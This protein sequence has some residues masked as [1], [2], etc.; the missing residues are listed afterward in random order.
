[1]TDHERPPCPWCSSPVGIK[2][3]KRWQK[4]SYCPHCHHC[5]EKYLQFGDTSGLHHCIDK[6]LQFGDTSG[7]IVTGWYWGKHRAHDPGTNNNE[8][9]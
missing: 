9:A 3:V 2:E 6:Y 1:M 4:H 7:L 5:I 8:A